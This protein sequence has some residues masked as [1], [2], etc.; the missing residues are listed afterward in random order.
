M[1]KIIFNPCE[2]CDVVPYNNGDAYIISCDLCS[3]GIAKKK[4]KKLKKQIKTLKTK[5]E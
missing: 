4:I 1:E 2:E 5:G 3:Y